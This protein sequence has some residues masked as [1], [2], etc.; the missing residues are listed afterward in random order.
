[1][2]LATLRIDEGTRAAVRESGT[3]RLLPFRNVDEVLA[4]KDWRQRVANSRDR[5]RLTVQAAE[6]APV[7]SAPGKIICCGHNYS[8]HIAELGR[9]VPQHP[10][11]FT[12]FADTLTGPHDDILVDGLSDAVDWEAELAVI[13]GSTVSQATAATASQ[14]IAGYTVANDISMRDWQLRTPQWLPGKAFDRT[15]PL[16]PVMVTADEFDPS[17]DSPSPAVSTAASVSDRTQRSSSS[18]PRTWWR[19]SPSSPLCAPAMSC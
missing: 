4:T 9:P 14:A 12:K 15:T 5:D 17:Q 7:L 8:E 6:F 18:A 2:E 3:Y 10:T 16:G 1:M 19:T 11:L 13:I